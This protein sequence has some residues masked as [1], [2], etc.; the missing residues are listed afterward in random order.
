MIAKR[1]ICSVMLLGLL[2]GCSTGESNG[3]PKVLAATVAVG[4]YNSDRVEEVWRS[5]QSDSFG[6]DFAIGPGDVLKI[7]APDV[8]E[9]KD[10]TERVS[11]DNTIN[12]PVAG[13]VKVGGDTEAQAREA[14]KRALSRLVKDPQVDVFVNEYSSRQVA[15]IGMVNKPGLYSLNSR[16]ETILDM[17]GQAGGMNDRASTMIMFIPAAPGSS[18]NLSAAPGLKSML[19]R[20]VQDSQVKPAGAPRIAEPQ[21]AVGPQASVRPA[22]NGAGQSSETLSGMLRQQH[23]MSIP[24]ANLGRGN[25]TDLPARPGDVIIVPNSGNVMVQGWV[26]NPGAYVV[27]SGLTTL[28]AVTAAGGQMFSSDVKI[29]RA[30]GDGQ[31]VAL[32]VDL[33]KVQKGQEAD[34]AVQGGDVVIVEKSAVGAVPYLFYT[35]FE[36]LG[37]GLALPV[38]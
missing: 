10:R 31:L 4:S 29:L 38:L 26:R 34:V 12:L 18:G 5:R 6:P 1:L 36:K 8:E 28:G 24:V 13:V 14:I 21:T 9:I 20:D 7:S 22:S 25:H 23:A 16:S 2:A 19:G 30:D 35:L 33:A 32:P 27:T 17:I 11:G 15:V 37:A 3:T